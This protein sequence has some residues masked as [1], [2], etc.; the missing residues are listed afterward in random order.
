MTSRISIETDNKQSRRLKT[1][2]PGSG[3]PPLPLRGIPP[4]G[5]ERAP[6]PNQ[7]PNPQKEEIIIR[8]LSRALRGSKIPCYLP[9][10]INQPGREV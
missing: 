10:L 4:Y 1:L 6:H 5:R 8:L 7:G 2:P 9:R 3:V